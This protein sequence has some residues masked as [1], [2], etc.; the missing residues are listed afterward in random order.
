M[1]T[2][3]QLRFISFLRRCCVACIV[4]F[5]CFNCASAAEEPAKLKVSGYGFFGNLELKKLLRTFDEKGEKREVYDANF[6]EDAALILISRINRDG[7][8]RPTI[9]AHVTLED[10][11]NQIYEWRETIAE[12]LPRPTRARRVEFEIKEGVFYYFDTIEFDGLLAIEVDDAKAFF[13]ERGAL[14]KFKKAR[15]FTQSR[16]ERGMSSLAEVLQ[17]NGYDEAKVSA[18]QLEKDDQTGAVNATIQIVEGLEFKVRSINK[19]VFYGTNLE[20]AQ[21]SA[22]ETNVTYS[23]LWEQDFAQGLRVTNF[24]RGYPDTTVAITT[25]NRVTTNNLVLLALSAKVNSGEQITLG[26]VRFT[27][28][29]KTKESLL[30][31]R[32]RLDEGE[33]LD[34]IAVDEGR[35]RLARLGIFDS[36]SVSY[37]KVDEQTRDVT[38]ELQEGKEVDV[39]ILFGFGTYELLRVGFE[40]NQ[41][42]IFGRAHHARLRVAQSFK[43]SSADYL[44][45][46][47]EFIGEDVDVFFNAFGLRREEISFTREEFGGGAGAKKFLK[48]ISSDFGVR[49][50]YQILNAVNSDIAKQV[51]VANAA[52]GSVTFDLRHDK[53]D[54]P[55]YP[56]EGYRISGSLETASEYLAGDVDYQRIEIGASFHQPIHRTTWLHIGLNHG[57]VFTEGSP[58]KELPFNKRFFPGGENSVRG[59]LE[60]EAAP[61]SAGGDVIGAETFLTANVELEQALSEKWSLVAFSDSIGF[62]KDI[63][64]YP[65][66]ET[67]FSVGL[68][69]RWRTVIGPIRLEYGHNLNPRNDDPA[70]T[71]H[72]S[73]GFPF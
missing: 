17:R 70:G 7:Y 2:N 44:Y 15:T 26:E 14:V 4:I 8:L 32:A 39:S 37:D 11:S 35:Y 33:L 1:E 5:L 53:R 48:S 72:F 47:P 46:M 63:G 34:R 43:T 25:I 45:T 38:Y 71:L 61:R 68:G 10:G 60:G 21:V 24:Q 54:N 67:L 29:Q 66:D 73:I 51:G 6:I 30:R 12:P 59:F 52:V 50:N 40:V 27:G 41:Y 69:V 42:N 18:E 22:V 65:F 49:Y 19:E 31:R 56:K 20:P 13:V 62:A 23:K 28:E 3:P 58:L 55:L 36:V 57:V 64:Q 9:V 16:L